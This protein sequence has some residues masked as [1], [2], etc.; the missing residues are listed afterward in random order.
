M[1]FFLRT[2]LDPKVLVVVL[3]LPKWVAPNPPNEPA[4][5]PKFD[6]VVVLVLP[7]WV[8]QSP[9]T[10]PSLKPKFDWVVGCKLA[11]LH[12]FC[13]PPPNPRGAN[14]MFGFIPP[15]LRP[16][17]AMGIPPGNVVMA[18]AFMVAAAAAAAAATGVLP[19]DKVMALAFTATA[20]VA[21]ALALG[22]EEVGV[23]IVVLLKES[24]V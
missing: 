23:C 22:G 9:T 7:E 16:M 6:W 19:G 4:L 24:W 21:A 12:E 3:V 11:E 5:K 13:C 1:L 14:V 8:A 10:E 2:W 17:T 20:A 15:T 18:L